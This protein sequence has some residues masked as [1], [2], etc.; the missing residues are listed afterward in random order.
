METGG[1]SA[2]H[3]SRAASGTPSG[4]DQ[5]QQMPGRTWLPDPLPA[6][7]GANELQALTLLRSCPVIG[8]KDR[9]TLAVGMRADV[10]VFDAGKVAERQPE[11]VND[12][13]GGAPRYI[14]RSSGYK[15][16]IVNG[17]VNV[18]DGGHTGVRAGAVL[19]HAR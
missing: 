19:R 5:D 11:L 8:L 6:D 3:L 1:L 10:N 17:K 4:G 12:F 16:T 2:V 9:G 15:A 18:L 13:P 14:P 7:F